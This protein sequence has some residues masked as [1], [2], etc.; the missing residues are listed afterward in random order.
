MLVSMVSVVRVS[1]HL[2]AQVYSQLHLKWGVGTDKAVG[3]RTKQDTTQAS[4]TPVGSVEKDF[5]T[6]TQISSFHY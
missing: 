6:A 5:P 1:K 3:S 4:S 2:K